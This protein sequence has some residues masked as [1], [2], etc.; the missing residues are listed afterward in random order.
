MPSGGWNPT[1]SACR[2]ASPKMQR[3]QGAGTAVD[4][5]RLA[6]RGKAYAEQWRGGEREVR[7]T[8]IFGPI[9]CVILQPKSVGAGI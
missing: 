4:R 3:A 7:Q 6:A 5:L 8:D 2:Q 1:P 9:R